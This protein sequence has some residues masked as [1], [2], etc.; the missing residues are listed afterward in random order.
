VQT[1]DQAQGLGGV[2][3]VG[4]S[5]GATKHLVESY[6][7][8]MA[9]RIGEDPPAI[10]ADAMKLGAPVVQSD[11]VSVAEC[12]LRVLGPYVA[13]DAPVTVTAS[14]EVLVRR[15]AAPSLDAYDC[16]GASCTID[17]GGPVYVGVV[18]PD[19]GTVD[20]QVAYTT[21][22]VSDPT[23]LDGAM[24]RDAVIVKA[25]WQRV[26]GDPLDT[27]D[28]SPPAMAARLAPGSDAT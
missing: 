15:G 1:Q 21:E 2:D 5:P 12:E 9:C 24:P 17:G 26:L 25:D 18:R 28:T 13:G 3:R 22:D 16:R 19:G 4:Y 23:C 7:R 6:A 14:D 27:F 11:R 20:V 10:A 8:Q